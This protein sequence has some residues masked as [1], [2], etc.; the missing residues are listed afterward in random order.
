MFTPKVLMKW[1]FRGVQSGL[2]NKGVFL[3]AYVVNRLWL[4]IKTHSCS[5]LIFD[6]A[7]ASLYAWLLYGSDENGKHLQKTMKITLAVAFLLF[8]GWVRLGADILHNN[9]Y[10]FQGDCVGCW[11]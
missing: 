5:G 1:G 11:E 10:N 8:F 2:V 9:P 6:D 3:F 4:Q 7:C